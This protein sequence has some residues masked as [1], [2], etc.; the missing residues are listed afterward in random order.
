MRA[1]AT[2]PRDRRSRFERA[3]PPLAL[4]VAAFFVW[5]RALDIYFSQ[6]DF[7]GLARSAG[8]VPRLHGP[9]RFLSAQAI[10][11]LLRPFADLSPRTYHA[12]N[13][14]V[15]IA[16]SV[17]L[18]VRLARPVQRPAALVGAVFF[19]VHPALFTAVY[20]IAAIGDPL[21][22]GF[23]LLTVI[24]WRHTRGVRWLA[25]PLYV[26]ALM[27]KESAIPLPIALLALPRGPAVDPGP[28]A[29]LRN[30]GGRM[31]D[32][33]WLMLA[34]LATADALYFVIADSMGAS[35]GARPYALVFGPNLWRNLLTY[36]GWTANAWLPTVK[37]FS[38]SQD[39]SV[40]GWGIG[41]LALWLLGLASGEL[42]RRGW[43]AGG[44]WT[45]AFLI[46]YLP[47]ESHTYH[48]YL[49]TP[50]IGAA[51]CVA[52][53]LDVLFARLVPLRRTGAADEGAETDLG[54]PP[55]FNPSP[56]WYLG[57]VLAGLLTGNSLL[58]V[59][60]IETAPFIVPGLYSDPVVDRAF[61]A[62][63]LIESVRPALPPDSLVRLMVWTLP[64][65]GEISTPGD[66][67]ERNLRSAI[68]DG[69]GLR[70]ML[71]QVIEVGFANEFRPLDRSWRWVLARP[72]GEAQVLEPRMLEDLIRQH[73]PPH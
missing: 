12:A 70:V 50:M 14:I 37:S 73:G 3:L 46:P 28:R 52:I 29:T 16:C 33:L 11:D 62:K 63:R 54:P 58:L 42:R 71:P 15:H 27:S 36:L 25:V 4:I 31:R 17:I 20:W 72:T 5:H 2:P 68:Y 38:D 60:R 24:A 19:A 48:Y 39:P 21:A 43:F 44:V 53:A 67:V 45:F 65:P 22:C 51:V 18:Y 23:V 64:P 61:I 56:A 57:I 47:I 59:R 7:V 69:V 40:W 32:P 6:D 8:L 9:W 41:A 26:L 66:Y 1:P 10:F 49:Y 55:A 30:V 13:L 35:D 34:A